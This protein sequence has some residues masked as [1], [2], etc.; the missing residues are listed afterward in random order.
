MLFHHVAKVERIMNAVKA[1]KKSVNCVCSCQ[2]PVRTPMTREE[3]MLSMSPLVVTAIACVICMV[4]MHIADKSKC[5][6]LHTYT[7]KNIVVGSTCIVVLG[8]L[9]FIIYQV[10]YR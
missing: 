8:Y 4:L 2:K 6:F 1:V 3:W 7:F 10:C 9:V 5:D